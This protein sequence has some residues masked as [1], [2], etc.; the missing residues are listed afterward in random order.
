VLVK[1]SRGAALETLVDDLA[2]G[3]VDGRAAGLDDDQS[4][5]L[6][7]PDEA[8]ATPGSGR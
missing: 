8:D 5:G 4:P 2:A 7:A 6:V 1:A 3:V